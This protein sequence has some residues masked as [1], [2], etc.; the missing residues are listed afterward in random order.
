MRTYAH[1]LY[2]AAVVTVLLLLLLLLHVAV[3]ARSNAS[4]TIDRIYKYA[5]HEL[6]CCGASVCVMYQSAA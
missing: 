1:T 3:N 2:I 6:N 4:S 5:V